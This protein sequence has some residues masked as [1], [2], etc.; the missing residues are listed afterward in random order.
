MESPSHM[1]IT[2]TILEIGEVVQVSDRFRKR[3]FVVEYA[4]NK[5]YPEFIKFEIVQ[6]SISPASFFRIFVTTVG[7]VTRVVGNVKRVFRT[8]R[9]VRGQKIQMSL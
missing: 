8:G 3:E 1:D 2:G 9:G 5:Q 4:E 7:I 6:D